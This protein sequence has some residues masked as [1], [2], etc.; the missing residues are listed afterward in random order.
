MVFNIFVDILTIVPN[1]SKIRLLEFF[2]VL[3]SKPLKILNILWQLGDL[4]GLVGSHKV[5]IRLA[6][7]VR[8]SLRVL[9]KHY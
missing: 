5:E 3:V 1:A 4:L 6:S 7:K 2:V 8:H 9:V